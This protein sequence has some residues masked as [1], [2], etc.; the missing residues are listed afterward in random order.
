MSAILG[1]L[2]RELRNGV[3]L[4]SINPKPMRHGFRDFRRLGRRQGVVC[5][6]P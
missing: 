6:E 3:Q 5:G 1:G 4:D 2:A